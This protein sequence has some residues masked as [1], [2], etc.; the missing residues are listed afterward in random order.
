MYSTWHK[1]RGRCCFG[2]TRLKTRSQEA[3]Q[4]PT[5]NQ[6]LESTM[7]RGTDRPRSMAR[8]R[9]PCPALVAVADAWAGET[10]HAQHHDT[11]GG[12]ARQE[13]QA[14]PST[15]C[16]SASAAHGLPAPPS[17]VLTPPL[18]NMIRTP[19]G[20]FRHGRA[21]TSF[22]GGKRFLAPRVSS[23]VH[24]QAHAGRLS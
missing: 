6:S 17:P 12:L 10:P 14:V 21:T 8:R 3:K 2:E 20:Y 23:T 4:A 19:N 24:G 1:K 18:T 16:S 7:G 15:S 5:R 13:Y 9:Q 22:L 11:S